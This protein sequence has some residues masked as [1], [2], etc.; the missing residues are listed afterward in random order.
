M[1][2]RNQM[3]RTLWFV[4]L[5]SLCVERSRGQT[6]SDA[7]GGAYKTYEDAPAFSAEILGLPTSV[8]GVS[9]VCPPK[10]SATFELHENGTYTYQPALNEYSTSQGDLDLFSYVYLNETGGYHEEYRAVTHSY[11]YIAPVNDAPIAAYGLDTLVFNANQDVI[12]P[13]SIY[14]QDVRRSLAAPYV[15]KASLVGS[16]PD[17]DQLTYSILQQATHGHVT[18]VEGSWFQYVPDANFLGL[19]S[20]V[21][22]ANDSLGG[23]HIQGQPNNP[24]LNATAEVIVQVGSSGE[25]PA[26]VDSYVGTQEDTSVLGQFIRE[27]VGYTTNFQSFFRFRTV[28]DPSNGAVE[29]SCDGLE[30]LDPDSCSTDCAGVS[31][32]SCHSSHPAAFFRYHPNIDTFGSDEFFFTYDVEE[33]GLSPTPA[34]VT[35]TVEPVNDAP[36]AVSTEVPAPM[37]YT[38]GP[39]PVLSYASVILTGEDIDSPTLQA[40]VEIPD[41][42]DGRLYTALGDDGVPLESSALNLQEADDNGHVALPFSDA[43]EVQLYYVAPEGRRGAWSLPWSITDGEAESSSASMGI[44]VSCSPG[45]RVQSAASCAPC[46][47]GLKSELPDQRSCTPCGLGTASVGG[48]ST[49]A[50]CNET[51]YQDEMGATLC[52]ACPQYSSG[53]EGQTSIES[54]QCLPGYYG[55]PGATCQECPNEG[56]W[57][58]C[59]ETNLRWPLPASGFWVDASRE[60]V[61]IHQCFPVEACE[62]FTATLVAG[63]GLG[64]GQDAVS[65]DAVSDGETCS[66]GYEGT[67]CSECSAGHYRS[68]GQC[69]TCTD[70]IIVR[71]AVMAAVLLLPIAMNLHDQSRSFMATDIGLTHVQ[72]IGLFRRLDLNW[73]SIP[74]KILQFFLWHALPFDELQLECLSAV[75]DAWELYKVWLKTTIFLPPILAAALAIGRG[76]PLLSK[77]AVMARRVRSTEH[78]LRTYLR[79]GLAEFS[80][81]K[82]WTGL[83]TW[84]AHVMLTYSQTLQLFLAL[85]SVT[86]FDCL[87]SDTDGQFYMKAAPNVACYE[88]GPTDKWG[89]ML[90]WAL[91]GIVVYV[92]APIVGVFLLLTHVFQDAGGSYPEEGW[93]VEV[94]GHLFCETRRPIKQQAPESY[95][96]LLQL[97]VMIFRAVIL[98]LTIH[99]NVAFSGSDGQTALFQAIF[100]MAVLAALINLNLARSPYSNPALRDSRTFL[101]YTELATLWIGVFSLADIS[102]SDETKISMDTALVL[103]LVVSYI[104]AVVYIPVFSNR[105]RWRTWVASLRFDVS[106]TADDLTEKEESPQADAPPARP[107]G[108]SRWVKAGKQ[109][110]RGVDLIGN[111]QRHDQQHLEG[112]SAEGKSLAHHQWSGAVDYL[113]QARG[114]DTSPTDLEVIGE[115]LKS[116][117]LDALRELVMSGKADL[118]QVVKVFSEVFLLHEASREAVATQEDLKPFHA[119][120]KP[121]LRMQQMARLACCEDPS[122]SNAEIARRLEELV[123]QRLSPAATGECGTWRWNKSL[124]QLLQW[125]A[126]RTLESSFGHELRVRKVERAA[127]VIQRNYR[128]MV[129]RKG[130]A[131]TAISATAPVPGATAI[132][133]VTFLNPLRGSPE[134]NQMA[135]HALEGEMGI[136]AIDTAEMT[137]V[138]IAENPLGA[139]GS[140]NLIDLT[141][142]HMLAYSASEAVATAVLYLPVDDLENEKPVENSALG[143]LATAA[144]LGSSVTT[145]NIED[146]PQSQ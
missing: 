100:C 123:M 98:A 65:M 59:T 119:Y 39:N 139:K 55:M 45:Y 75:D 134:S 118:R 144:T 32:D 36:V 130:A 72:V 50:L 129:G 51:A 14:D 101:F 34:S 52:K 79:G 44:N 88:Y 91:A 70:A 24:G 103:V 124:G 146:Q 42:A 127:T 19:D 73:P 9:L 43:A 66:S 84:V 56:V 64:C 143:R 83:A 120:L 140:L 111:L 15:L 136:E 142:R 31:R 105:A 38:S 135:R 48:F 54:C 7:Y 87:K 109:V 80:E 17:G 30:V 16:D 82:S 6:E 76:C 102:M 81:E 13:N 61:D 145:A 99:S 92:V 10:R 35:V 94:S 128:T 108:E 46:E 8:S 41:A 137:F 58:H 116:N 121:A 60:P 28:L 126:V 69:L 63:H 95:E 18:I 4:R 96:Y 112:R 90:P 71:V 97:R 117:S 21:Y 106:A 68:M 89:E 23:G 67:S 114:K 133:E 26:V 78:L 131:S 25:L 62:G 53:E 125:D 37:T 141:G 11:I 113:A 77:E 138:A 22:M 40:L 2:N 12:T 122:V 107:Q 110:L 85:G 20:F 132:D 47:A 57:T 3:Q 29:V 27:G 93:L 1:L 5:V 49:C 74:G 86:L 33:Q 115:T 104:V